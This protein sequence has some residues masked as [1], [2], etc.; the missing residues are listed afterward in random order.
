MDGL[1]QPARGD[2]RGADRGRLA[3]HRRHRRARR[4]RLPAIT[5]RKKDLFKTSGGK[6]IAPQ[7]IEAKFKALCP[8]VSQFIVHGDERNF[9]V[10]LITLDPDAM[11]G[12][13]AENGMAGKSY[14]EIV[15]LRRRCATMVAG[16]RRR[17]QRAAQPLGD[18]QEVRA[19]STTT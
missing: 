11:H 1:P 14:A 18:D 3:A 5:D 15:A 19:S 6:Y 12:W 2:R 13:A 8:Y 4:R 17:A 10:A 7:A 9:C 16:V